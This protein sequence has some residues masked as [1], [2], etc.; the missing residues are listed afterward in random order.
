MRAARRPSAG[1]GARALGVAVVLGTSC[2]GIAR[3][4]APLVPTVPGGTVTPAAV[5]ASPVGGP[6]AGGGGG[7]APAG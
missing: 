6:W 1:T 5:E 7:G 4:Q 2:P 3:A